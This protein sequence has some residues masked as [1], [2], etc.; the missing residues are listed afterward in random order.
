MSREL[1]EQGLPWRWRPERVTQAIMAKG[2]N[3]AVVREHGELVAFGIME[4]HD[5]DAHLV[6]FAVRKA[7]Q[8]QGVGSALLRWLETV[9]R[10]SGAE[11][12]RLAALRSND[13]ARIF[14]NEHG[15]HERV[16]KSRM[17]SGLADGILLEKYLRADSEADSED[18]A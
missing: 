3:V 1:I 10:V 2:N 8:R 17:Y 14:Y 7:R 6:L 12:I 5:D 13:A 16:I 4:Y 9:A 15:Y 11:R 18:G